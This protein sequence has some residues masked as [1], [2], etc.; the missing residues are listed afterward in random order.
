MEGR[1][2]TERRNLVEVVGSIDLGFSGQ[3]YTRDRS[4]LRAV[5]FILDD[6]AVK[7]VPTLLLV[8]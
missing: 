5:S 6:F 7:D 2:S 3:A 4:H 8:T 1:S